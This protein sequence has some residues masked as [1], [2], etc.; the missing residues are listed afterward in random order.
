MSPITASGKRAVSGMTLYEHI[1]EARRRLLTVVV[2]VVITGTVCFIFYPEI[3]NW[4]REPYCHVQGKLGCS[5]LATGPL[6]GLNLRIKIGLFGGLLLALPVLFYELWRFVM[7]GLKKREKQYAIPFV[8]C[9]ITF[10]LA[11][12]VVAYFSFQH[13]L[14]FLKSFG[15]PDLQYHLNPVSYLNLIVLMMFLFGVIFELPVVLVSLELA[16]VVSPAQLLH[17]WR[18]AI[19]GLV[20]AA[21]V[22]TPSGDPVSMCVMAIPLIL[23]YY[24][25]IGV[26]KLLGK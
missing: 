20:I 1:K 23:F 8:V 25:A 4:L 10:F 7:P 5:F 21:A 9:S 15:G 3:L 19:I 13:A 14:G 24:G 26:G 16:N 6:D 17:V 2:A 12:C 18:P 22:L 11:G